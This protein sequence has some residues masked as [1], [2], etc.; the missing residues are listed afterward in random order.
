MSKENDWILRIGV[1]VSCPKLGIIFENK[2][3]QK[4]C[5]QKMCS[6]IDILQWKENS[7]DYIENLI[8][9]HFDTSHYTN[10]QNLIII[11]GYVDF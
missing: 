4:L 6:K 7:N 2:V 10:S 11:F 1:V 5:Y 8:L 3:I 9:A